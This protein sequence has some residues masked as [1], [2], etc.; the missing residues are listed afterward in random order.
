M[1]NVPRAWGAP[2]LQAVDVGNLPGGRVQL[3]FQ[4]SE[5]VNDPR[6]FTI[7]DPARIV[8][9]FMGAQSGLTENQREINQGAAEQ[10]TVLEGGDRT[11][12]AVNLTKMVPYDIRSQGNTVLLTLEAG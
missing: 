6:S 11:R 8:V 9:D 1:L 3:R 2:I 5:P 4:L 7:N 12:A 10:V